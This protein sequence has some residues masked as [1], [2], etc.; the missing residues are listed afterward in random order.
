MMR[1]MLLVTVGLIGG[2]DGCDQ[3]AAEPSE[4]SK[5]APTVRC[6]DLPGAARTHVAASEDLKTLFYIQFEPETN[7]QRS[8][9]HA[10]QTR[11]SRTRP[12]HRHDLYSVAIE[13]GSPTLITKDVG[14]KIVVGAASIFFVREQEDEDRFGFERKSQLFSVTFEGK[15]RAVSPPEGNVRD[16][17]LT[18][19]GKSLVF[20]YGKSMMESTIHQVDVVGG[21]PKQL[22]AESAFGIIGFADGAIIARSMFGAIVAIPLAGGDAKRL[23]LSGVGHS[24]QAKDHLFFSKA[25]QDP[26]GRWTDRGPLMH[27]EAGGASTLLSGSQENDHII[28]HAGENILVARFDDD[29]RSSTLLAADGTT[30]KPLVNVEGARFR[31]AVAVDG[32]QAVVIQ[33]D[34]NDDDF[35]GWDDESD[36]CVIPPEGVE[37]MAS[38]RRYPKAREKTVKALEN[39]AQGDL[40]KAKIGIGEQDGAMLAV[41]HLPGDGPTDPAEL[42]K[43]ASELQPRAAEAAGD[44]ALGVKI[45]FAA[46]LQEALAYVSP[47]RTPNIIAAGGPR[48]KLLYDESHFDLAMEPGTLWKY[49]PGQTVGSFDCRGKITNTGSAPRRVIVRCVLPNDILGEQIGE[50]EPK[51]NPIPPGATASYDFYVGAGEETDTVD[52]KLLEDER[53]LPFFNRVLDRRH[54]GEPV[55]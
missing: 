25:E 15:E 14:A 24:R 49:Q 46:N 3:P 6:L 12:S 4:A 8:A 26:G 34:S 53:E 40:E 28:G 18:P 38:G 21:E 29:K 17:A 39:L 52:I 20:T 7:E 41:F 31:S 36:L 43:R 2:C 13:G 51:P 32:G 54:K 19:D 44:S 50:G 10:K 23:A 27:F 37:V 55:E 42:R 45:A 11:F 1:A 5:P 30:L 47:H 33:Y 9:R 35:I 16:L 22:S 48:G